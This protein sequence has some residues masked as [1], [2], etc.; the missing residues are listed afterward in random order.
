MKIGKLTLPNPNAVLFKDMQQKT[1]R[2]KL[3]LSVFLC[4]LLLAVIA[5]IVLLA[6]TFSG[7]EDGYVD[8]ET[9][10]SLFI[11][12]ASTEAVILCL[13]TPS[14][15]SNSIT[16]ERE[17]QTFDVLLSTKLTPWEIIKG[18]YWASILQILLLI[19]SGLPVY[20]LVF[21]YG[22][23]SFFQA[24]GILCVLMVV[25]MFVASLGIF[26][27]S[28]KKK[29]LGAT[30]LTFFLMALFFAGTIFLV[31]L[32]YGIAEAINA[33]NNYSYSYYSSY[34]LT[35]G[36]FVFVLYANPIALVLDS[37]CYV[38]GIEIFGSGI[39]MAE[40]IS[41]ITKMSSGNI[42]LKYWSLFSIVVHLG[43]TYL[44][45]RASAKAI[46]PLRVRRR[47]RRYGKKS[48]KTTAQ[49]HTDNTQTS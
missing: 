41:D 31:F 11:G 19:I 40:L 10:N 4:N 27:S 49:L 1:K 15:T 5:I 24:F 34:Y 33:V 8:Y 32:A 13:I 42:L 35:P 17:K 22:G 28:V 46:D 21:I 14:L 30:I 9:L 29:T 12:L 16:A 48:K 45:L 37:F 44:F 23:V 26:A 18:K 47:N 2:V 25:A 6:M 3:A 20:S 7:I 38:F 43:L 39:G 36:P